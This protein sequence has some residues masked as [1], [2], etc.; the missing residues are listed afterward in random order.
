MN[1]NKHT[2]GE[3]RNRV[4]D[5]QLKVIVGHQTVA[6]VYGPE[7]AQLANAELITDAFNV[8]NQCGLT[9]SQLL[10]ETTLLKSFG[11]GLNELCQTDI[12]PEL[13]KLK[14]E[15]TELAEQ[16]NNLLDALTLLMEAVKIIYK[17]DTTFEETNTGII[18]TNAISKTLT[19]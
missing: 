3:A 5:S 2:Q 8:T 7:Q 13:A 12:L 10:E 9:P 16:R 18:V 6:F 19:I 4:E 17:G 1:S 15:K 14:K 11:K